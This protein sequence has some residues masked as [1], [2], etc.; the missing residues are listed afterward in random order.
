MA[1]L[2]ITFKNQRTKSLYTILWIFFYLIDGLEA[3]L[4][5][6]SFLFVHIFSFALLCS[7]WPPFVTEIATEDSVFLILIVLSIN[8]FNSF[9]YQSFVLIKKYLNKG[10]TYLV[11]MLKRFKFESEINNMMIISC[12]SGEILQC[13]PIIYSQS[14][15]T[16]VNL[17]S[18]QNAKFCK[19]QMFVFDLKSF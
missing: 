4:N 8:S 10:L 17:L 2:K 7:N 11:K 3:V 18:K 5:E 6:L 9:S 15:H 12:S 16:Q 19:I 14:V 1:L 13:I